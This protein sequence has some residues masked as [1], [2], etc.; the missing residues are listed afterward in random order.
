MSH[1]IRK[2]LATKANKFIIKFD[3]IRCQTF[4]NYSSSFNPFLKP[5]V[6]SQQYLPK[7]FLV[8]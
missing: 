8:E 1:N 5:L 3:N 4:K 6:G 2:L 7:L